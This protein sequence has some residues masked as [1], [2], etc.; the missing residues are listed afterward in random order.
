M[1]D[2]EDFKKNTTD[3]PY[4]SNLTQG[5][6]TFFLPHGHQ[7]KE[8]NSKGTGSHKYIMYYV[9]NQTFL[10]YLGTRLGAVHDG[11]TPV[12][13]ELILQLGQS[14]LLQLV[15]AVNHPPVGLHEHGRAQVLV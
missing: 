14:L 5:Q 1:Q 11:V 7:A 3:R 10:A 15:S 12:Q 8:L 6:T 4:L 2:I 13:R 9:Q